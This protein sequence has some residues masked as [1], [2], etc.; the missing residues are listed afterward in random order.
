MR[1]RERQRQ[2]KRKRVVL[3]HTSHFISKINR[4]NGENKSIPIKKLNTHVNPSTK[5]GMAAGQ[6]AGSERKTDKKGGCGGV[7]RKERWSPI[8]VI[9]G[10]YCH[11]AIRPLH[12]AHLRFCILFTQSAA[13]GEKKNWLSSWDMIIYICM[14]E[15]CHLLKSSEWT[16]FQNV[17]GLKR[18]TYKRNWWWWLFPH[19]HKYRR[20]ILTIFFLPVPFF[21]S[22]LSGDQLAQTSS[23]FFFFRPGSVHS[24]SGSWDNCGREKKQK[25]LMYGFTKV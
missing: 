8:M 5:E 13:C 3:K 21:F 11:C 12:A 9:F 16:R 1:E 7:V 15:S 17:G 22:F 14:G 2:R 25:K 23:T 6:G 18:T 4:K 24:S 10:H 19:W 20:N